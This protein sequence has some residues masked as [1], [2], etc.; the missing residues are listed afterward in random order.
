M[1]AVVELV[2]TNSTPS[3]G[4]LPSIRVEAVGAIFGN[5]PI[6]C[7]GYDYGSYYDFADTCISYQDSQWTQS[8][9][10]NEE[11]LS[12]AGVQINS[13]TFWIL[14]GDSGSL[15]DSTEFI[16]EG[17]TNGVLGPKLPYKLDRMC[18]VKLSDQEI[19]V[20]GGE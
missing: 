1:L 2:K 11:R 19:F 8:H 13:T 20:I 6:I 7:G 18:A 17:Q 9:S 12:A 10:M 14:G 16:I 5:T 3:F 4:Q 15:L